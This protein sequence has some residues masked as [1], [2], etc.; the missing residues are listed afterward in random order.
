MGVKKHSLVTVAARHPIPQLSYADAANRIAGTNE[1]SSITLAATN[2]H[3]IAHQRDNDTF[4]ILLDESPITWAQIILGTGGTMTDLTLTGDLTL[5]GAGSNYIHESNTQTSGNIFSIKST[6]SAAS[7]ATLMRLDADGT[8]WGSG[9]SVLELVSDDDDAIPL[10]INDGSTD[11]FFVARSGTIVTNGNLQLSGGGNIVSS[12]N[13]SVSVIPNGTG[14]FKVG[15]GSPTMLTPV[16]GESYF[17]AA[18]E[19]AGN[20]YPTSNVVTSPDQNMWFGGAS[21]SFAMASHSTTQTN[22]S[23]LVGLGSVSKAMILCDSGDRTFNFAHSVPSNPTVFFHSSNQSTTEWGSVTHD[24]TDFVLNQGKG[25]TKL[26]GAVKHNVTT[27]NAATYNLALT[28]HILH[29]TYTSTAAVT[30]LQ[31]MTASVASGRVIHIKD[32]G[33]NASANNITITTEGAETI[34]G[35]ATYTLS[36]DYESVS[37]YSN[38]TNWFAF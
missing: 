27:V 28:D 4:W 24:Q 16:T 25:A 34:D 3:S 18:V 15:S 2:V 12:S 8:N 7:T 9:A 36:T 38:G 5:S 20:L 10:I 17:S 13:G 29:V 26:A 31:L 30:N 21:A 14:I 22:D 19:I 37:F 33:G 35:S 11:S 23:F 6:P 1:Q 32:A